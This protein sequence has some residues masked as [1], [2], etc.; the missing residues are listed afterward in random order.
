MFFDFSKE[1]YM[2]RDSAREFLAEHLPTTRL[3]ELLA[4]DRVFD[5]ALVGGAAGGDGGARR[6]GSARRA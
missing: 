3:R 2:A 6:D 4:A 5:R 1:Q